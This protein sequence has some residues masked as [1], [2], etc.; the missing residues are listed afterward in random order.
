M[1]RGEL[2]SVAAPSG[3]GKSAFALATV[4]RIGRPTLFFSADTAAYTAAVR[5]GAMLTGGS[6]SV[7]EDYMANVPGW[8]EETLAQASHISWD[9]NG[10]PDLDHIDIE[11]LA[12]QEMHGEAPEILVLDNLM[13]VADGEDEW[14]SMR[15]TNKELAF[16]ARDL[17]CAVLVLQHTNEENFGDGAPSR[18]RVQGKD[19]RKPAVI[20]TM[21]QSTHDGWMPLA[22]VKNR[23]GPVDPRAE[24]PVYLQF[25]GESMT[26]AD[27]L[28]MEMSA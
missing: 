10:A 15:R 21:G 3:A 14:Q 20:L 22:V 13:D 1:R 4:L 9:F 11:V 16:L 17:G 8:T 6:Q 5:L 27:P 26:I 12:Y 23:G 28:E 2:F 19:L 25:I 24:N 7:V 18:Y